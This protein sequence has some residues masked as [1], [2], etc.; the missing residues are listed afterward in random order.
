MGFPP[1]YSSS[2]LHSWRAP[3]TLPVGIRHRAKLLRTRKQLQLPSV[4]HEIA[5]RIQASENSTLCIEESKSS[6]TVATR[7]RSSIAIVSDGTLPA[8]NCLNSEEQLADPYLRTASV[9][10]RHP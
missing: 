6:T 9:T 1:Q 7:V 3:A 5:S 8:A 10:P 2:A 4:A